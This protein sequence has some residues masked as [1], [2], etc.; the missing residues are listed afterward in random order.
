MFAILPGHW[1]IPMHAGNAY[2][3]DNPDGF[4][5]MVKA[6]RSGHEPLAWIIQVRPYAEVVMG[7]AL[8]RPLCGPRSVWPREAGLSVH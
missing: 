6:T 3:L 5:T 7:C 1:T 8:R 2:I 4:V